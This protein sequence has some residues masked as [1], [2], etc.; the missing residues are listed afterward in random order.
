MS[1]ASVYVQ[2]VHQCVGSTEKYQVIR[3]ERRSSTAGEKR[4]ECRLCHKVFKPRF[5]S[6]IIMPIQSGERSHIGTKYKN[7]FR[8]KLLQVAS[9]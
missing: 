3:D 8:Q 9:T 7:A 2:S 1:A 4:Y 6:N 5:D